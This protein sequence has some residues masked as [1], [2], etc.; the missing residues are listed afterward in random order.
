[1]LPFSLNSSLME[2][3]VGYFG[4]FCHFLVL[5]GINWFQKESICKNIFLMLVFL[6]G[7]FLFLSFC[8]YI[9][10]CGRKKNTEN[11]E[12]LRPGNIN[13]KLQSYNIGLGLAQKVIGYN[14]K[15]YHSVSIMSSCINKQ[16]YFQENDN[17]E[18][19]LSEE[20]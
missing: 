20:I 10:M 6:K 15:E 3:Q 8:Y 1:M 12:N 9:L 5:D 17:E 16:S 13:I 18:I 11:Q 14:Q 19:V 4:L 7:S 2:F